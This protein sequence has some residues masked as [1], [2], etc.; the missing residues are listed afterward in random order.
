MTTS[1]V[2][3]RLDRTGQPM[4]RHAPVLASEKAVSYD[5][6]RVR[7]DFPIL[8][9]K[10]LPPPMRPL[11]RESPSSSTQRTLQR[12]SSSEEQQKRST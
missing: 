3:R 11:G 12:L 8:K 4:Q 10:R 1:P 6:E 5:L 2:N 9:R 7:A